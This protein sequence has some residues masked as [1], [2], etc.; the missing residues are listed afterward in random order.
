[1]NSLVQMKK[2]KH[3]CRTLFGAVL[4]TSA[5][6]VIFAASCSRHE[7][8]GQSTILEN[9]AKMQIVSEAE[10]G[11]KALFKTTFDPAKTRLLLG[12]DLQKWCQDHEKATGKVPQPTKE[13]INR[14]EG[15]A[16]LIQGGRP[17]KGGGNQDVVYMMRP[18]F[19]VNRVFVF[20]NNDPCGDGNPATCDNCTGCHGE[21]VPGGTISTCVCTESCDVCH[22]CP[23]C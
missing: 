7:S 11:F 17:T 16:L 2:L 6:F 1:M 8:S 19:G 3:V 14:N 4:V 21:S 9:Q 12:S 23:D 22:A 15:M 13:W 20:G 10:E 5:G 18:R